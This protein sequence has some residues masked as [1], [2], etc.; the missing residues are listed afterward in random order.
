MAQLYAAA[1]G[2]A[3]SR[4]KN[5]SKGKS[6]EQQYADLGGTEGN[7]PLDP[8]TFMPRR[9][10]DGSIAPSVQHMVNQ[11]TYGYNRAQRDAA[12]QVLVN[13]MLAS[14]SRRPGSAASGMLGAAGQLSQTHLASQVN[15]P[16]VLY[17]ARQDAMKQSR[18]DARQAA[19]IKAGVALV[20]AAATAATGGA[21]APLAAGL[22]AGS[23]LA[24][25]QGSNS[26]M[27]G[28]PGPE[29]A[30]GGGQFAPQGPGA[31]GGEV[32]GEIPQGQGMEARMAPGGGGHGTPAGGTVGPKATGPGQGAPSTPG[33]GSG[34]GAGPSSGG[35][36]P[37]GGPQI[38]PDMG[39]QVSAID[40]IMDASQS[41]GVPSH[42]VLAAVLE[43]EPELAD[44]N[45]IDRALYRLHLIQ[46]HDLPEQYGDPD[47][48]ES[49]YA[50]AFG[51]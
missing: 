49:S 28:G 40:P 51:A 10:P 41:L 29:T 8:N 33:G 48:V 13:Q 32:S 25:G 50:G 9:L 14:S 47:Y 20:G 44:S 23:Y 16:D 45:H 36:P 4:L 27:T 24:G 5:R 30:P 11:A 21:A 37:G 3:L 26:E 46:M 43:A 12:S 17:Y 35:G 15:P 39:I 38:G 34:G 19:Y 2:Y 42:R 1:A 7:V 6:R 31:G 18:Q 22:I